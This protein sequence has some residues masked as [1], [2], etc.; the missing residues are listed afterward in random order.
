MSRIVS[1]FLTLILT[2]SFCFPPGRV[3][4]LQHALQPA[5]K[6]SGRWAKTRG[7]PVALQ[8]SWPAAQQVRGKSAT[9]QRAWS[10]RVWAWE[11]SNVAGP[12]N[13]E[14]IAQRTARYVHDPDLVVERIPGQSKFGGSHLDRT[15]YFHSAVVHT[16]VYGMCLNCME[17]IPLAKTRG[18]CADSVVWCYFICPQQGSMPAESHLIQSGYLPINLN[19][20]TLNPAHHKD[21]WDDTL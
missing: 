2:W 16:C 8:W 18:D 1:L 4:R 5:S 12:A 19:C 15:R 7:W 14:S 11:R 10:A 9:T 21:M 3:T 13:S 17:D 6:L 20:L